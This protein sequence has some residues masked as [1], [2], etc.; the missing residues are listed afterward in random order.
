MLLSYENE[1]IIARANGADLDYVVPDDTL[2]IQ[3]PAAVLKDA[4]PKAQDLLD[5]ITSAEGQAHYAQS[6]FR[7][8]VDGVTLPEVAGANDPAN[9]FPQP[10]ALYTIDDDFGGW[11]TANSTFFDEEAGIITELQQETGKLE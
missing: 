2:L 8:V 5:Y 6:G 10:S 7:P 1:A 11:A 9:P 3:N 4:D